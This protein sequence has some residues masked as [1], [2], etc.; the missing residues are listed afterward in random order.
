M[1]LLK[2]QGNFILTR[3]QKKWKIWNLIKLFL[4]DGGAKLLNPINNCPTSIELFFASFFF[5]VTDDHL[6]KMNLIIVRLNMEGCTCKIFCN[7]VV[8]L[9]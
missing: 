8:L 6:L 1:S 4:Q 3:P 7:T 5:L 2:M 9:Y